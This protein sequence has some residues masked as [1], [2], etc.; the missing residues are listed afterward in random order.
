MPSPSIITT[1]CIFQ[2]ATDVQVYFPLS[3]WYN[4]YSGQRIRGMN[5]WQEFP[6][7]IDTI[8]LFVR[9]GF[10]VPTQHPELTAVRR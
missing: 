5:S 6:A 3:Q 8:H 4:F 10:V 9:G 7:A 2:G 1:H